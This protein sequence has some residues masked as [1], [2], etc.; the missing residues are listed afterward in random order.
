VTTPNSFV[1]LPVRLDDEQLAR[2]GDAPS[3]VRV[4]HPEDRHVTV[5]FFGPVDAERA[6]AVFDGSAELDVPAFEATLGEV[7][8]LGNKRHP[9]AL[10][11]LITADEATRGALER[12]RDALLREAEAKPDARPLLLHLTLGRF[13]R[14]AT[15]G[16]RASAIEWARALELSGAKVSLGTIALFTWSE[17]RRERLF[18]IVGERRLREA[19]SNGT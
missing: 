9:S 17:D 13:G 10:T 2:F 4:F 1:G 6:R 16:D 15:P 5:A 18:R 19:G 14:T 8:L 11:L 12:A 3:G 7:E